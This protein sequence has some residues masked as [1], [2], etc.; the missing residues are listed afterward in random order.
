[1]P[2]P[3][4]RLHLRVAPGAERSAVV[5]RYGTGWK[6]RV[7]RAPERGKANAELIQLL[8]D[9]LSVPRDRVALVGGHRGRD[10]VVA[11]DGITEDEAGRRLDLA[12]ESAR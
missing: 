4:V 2:D 1:M 3:S 10:K 9:T 12:A 7:A 11:L 5:G 6:V 8:A